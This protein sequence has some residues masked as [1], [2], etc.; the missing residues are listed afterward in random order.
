MELIPEALAKESIPG[1]ADAPEAD[2]DSIA[3]DVS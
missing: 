3:R 1:A 2:M